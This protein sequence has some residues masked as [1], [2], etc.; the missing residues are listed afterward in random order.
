[1]P[2]TL[3]NSIGFVVVDCRGMDCRSGLLLYEPI[4]KLCFHKDRY[5]T[6]NVMCLAGM[7]LFPYLIMKGLDGESSITRFVPGAGCLTI[8]RP[9]IFGLYPLTVGADRLQS[10]NGQ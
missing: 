5:F 8:V 4:S 9:R 2:V 3:A 1:M 10:E 6:D 7:W